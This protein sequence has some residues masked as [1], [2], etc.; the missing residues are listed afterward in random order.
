MEKIKF[1]EDVNIIPLQEN[2]FLYKNF[3]DKDV[4]KTYENKLNSLDKDQWFK[5]ENYEEG[6]IENNYWNGKLSTDI[7]E[8]DFLNKLVNYFAPSHW[9]M[10]NTNFV[11][12]QS[13]QSS[14]DELSTGEFEGENFILDNA[15]E[16]C[17][18]IY[19]GEWEGG[20]INFPLANFKYLPKYG[21]MLIF[22]PNSNHFTEEVRSGVRYAY[23][24][25][26]IKNP[27]YFMP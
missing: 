11:R 25:Y 4:L 14:I 20:E 22:K 18:A 23:Q 16:Y 1:K 10:Q 2:I 26:L 5:H 8:S 13:G 19:F 3:F 21:D 17:I 27:G 15:F 7:I 12:L 24:D 9:I 6:D